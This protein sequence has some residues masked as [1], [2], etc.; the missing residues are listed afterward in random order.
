MQLSAPQ[1]NVLETELYFKDTPIQ[2]IGGYMIFEK[3]INYEILNKA[4]NKL[5]K[6]A[7]GLRLRIIKNNNEFSQEIN[8]YKYES[9]ENIGIVKDI[10]EQCK[11]WMSI[12]RKS[13]LP[14][15]F[16]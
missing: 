4:F 10:D 9:M 2:N 12:H 5:L 8:P 7:D 6:N 13:N 11:R 14:W 16:P 3:E 1:K 15:L